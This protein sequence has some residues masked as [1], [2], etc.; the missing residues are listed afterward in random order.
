MFRIV[1]HLA[2][3]DVIQSSHDQFLQ[4]VN[5]AQHFISRISVGGTTTSSTI[6]H[7]GIIEPMRILTEAI[8]TFSHRVNFS[9]EI[10]QL[11]QHQSEQRALQ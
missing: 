5:L 6:T 8:H 7:I 4:R 3:T 10:N 1:D 9:I 2:P 11:L